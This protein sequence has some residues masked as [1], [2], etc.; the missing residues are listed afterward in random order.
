M[1]LNKKKLLQ[2]LL[3]VTLV[4]D[5][6]FF[7]LGSLPA[8]FGGSAT[9]LIFPSIVSIIFFFLFWMINK[10]IYLGAYYK[11]IIILY[12]FIIFS[13]IYSVMTYGF[14]RNT[15]IGQAIRFLI[16]LNY[17]PFVSFIKEYGEDNL[18][19]IIEYVTISL[20]VVLLVQEYALLH[21]GF[22]FLKIDFPLNSTGR[23]FT[24][25]EGIVRIS[26]LLSAYKIINNQFKI[27]SNLISWLNFLLCLSA[28]LLVDQSRIYFLSVAI[29]ILV[30]ILYEFRR[31]NIVQKFMVIILFILITAIIFG[32][33]FNSLLITLND[34]TSGSNYA[35]NGA[36]EYYSYLM[37]G[38]WL[39]GLGFIV[40]GT[41]D[42][43]FT[44]LKGPR[45][46]Y[47][48]SDIGIFGIYFSM[49]IIGVVWYLWIIFKGIK[50]SLEK[51]N[52]ILPMGLIAEIIVSLF[53]M[54]YF[55]PARIPALAL[56]L[57][58]VSSMPKNTNMK[59]VK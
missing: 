13:S 33:F 9:N 27:K 56:F 21:W 19:K 47:N 3:F 54:S 40:P 59:K 6:R 34:P 25:A 43:A 46:I 31:L 51:N 10:K 44:L 35:R 17:F 1:I 12:I 45:G 18:I 23:I 49:G 2:I 48:I 28:I 53:T 38:K 42:P 32:V 30:M 55:D 50:L 14:S 22:F 37:K 39:S 52:S 7:Y 4:A 8:S 36:I 5:I 26:V 24:V 15:V 41:N 58:F 20:C 29:G 16:L 57:A 11:E